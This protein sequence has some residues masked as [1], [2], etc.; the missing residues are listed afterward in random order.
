MRPSPTSDVAA[1]PAPRVAHRRV[2]DA[3]GRPRGY[4]GRM[5]DR[6]PDANESVGEPPARMAS[7]WPAAL[8]ILLIV[9]LIVA[10][11]Y[12]FGGGDAAAAAV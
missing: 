9:A 7:W 10:L 11:V 5:T 6:Q 1:G 2:S 4:G 12:L 8:V 3:R